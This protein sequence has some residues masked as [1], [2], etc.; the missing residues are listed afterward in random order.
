M[1]VLVD[2]L[3]LSDIDLPETMQPSEPALNESY[4]VAQFYMLADNVTG[5]LALGSFSASNFSAFQY[6][7]LDGLVKL[8]TL[9]ATQLLVDV[10]SSKY[11][12]SCNVSYNL[13]D[14]R[15]IMGE[16]SNI[17]RKS[18]T[19]EIVIIRLYL[20]RACECSASKLKACWLLMTD[21]V[22]A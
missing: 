16:V 4:S 3:P 21:K 5:V 9:G 12:L 10:V 20:Y 13:P 15:Q 7:L 1:N 14:S 17:L 18:T 19:L 22:A 2:A 6:S 8:K 11:R